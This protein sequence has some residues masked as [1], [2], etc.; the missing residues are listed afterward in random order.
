MKFSETKPLVRVRPLVMFTGFLGAGKTTLLRNTLDALAAD[1]VLVDVILNDREN[2]NLD[3]ETL[4]DHAA[5]VI[6]LAGSCVCCDSLDELTSMLLKAA[7]SGHDALFLEI[8][9]T[10][11]P[12]PLQESFTLLESRFLLRP[13]WQ[14]CVIDARL[15]GKRGFYNALEALQLETASHF[16]LSHTAELNNKTHLQLLNDIRAINPH[17]TAIDASSLAKNLVISLAQARRHSAALASNQAPKSSMGRFNIRAPRTKDARH[18]LAHEFT[19]CQILLP[20]PLPAIK[21]VRWLGALPDSVIRAKVLTR[22]V[23]QPDTRHLFERVGAMVSPD[24][25]VVPIREKVPS[26][27]ILLGADL[28]P[29]ELIFT[30]I[31]LFPNELKHYHYHPHHRR[32]PCGTRRR[33]CP[34]TRRP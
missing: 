31:A 2:A 10:S 32:G 13:R 4:R 16:H 22:T 11:D 6:P 20:D 23:S 18:H 9:G 26:S 5:S 17:A 24:P 34:S 27:A 8:N 3:C 28:D 21:I 1:E 15:F 25:L 19:G 7:G 33:Y 29:E 14:V 30:L 12:L